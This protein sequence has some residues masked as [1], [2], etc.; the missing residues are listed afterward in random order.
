MR[1]DIGRQSSQSSSR[2]LRGRFRQT[3]KRKVM[4]VYK[5]LHHDVAGINN[6]YNQVDKHN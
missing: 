5:L 2:S 3:L 4:D 1:F 6:N